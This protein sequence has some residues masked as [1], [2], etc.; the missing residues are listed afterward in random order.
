MQF[1]TKMIPLAGAIAF[2]FAGA[3]SAQE[4]VVKI[5]HVGPMTGAIAHL[6]K[7]NENGARM[8]DRRTER[9]GHHHRRQ[10]GQVRTARRRRRRRSEARHRGRAEAG[11]RQGQRRHRPPELRHHDPGL[12]DLQRRRHPADLAVGDQPEVHPARASRPTF[13]VVA[14]DGQLGGTLGRYAVKDAEG[15]VDRR[16]RRPHRLRPGRRRRIRQGRQ[17]SRG[18][19]DRRAR[20]S[21]T[22]RRPT[23]TPS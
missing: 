1:N 12:E 2:A 22:T 19:S 9:Q 14:N 21:P 10:E 16:D 6:G 11:R 18:G 5:G 23:S 7:D 17:G 15:Q 20:S 13:R 3:A 4:K 8:A